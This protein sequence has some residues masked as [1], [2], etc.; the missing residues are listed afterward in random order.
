MVQYKKKTAYLSFS[1]NKSTSD[2]SN[3]ADLTE[4]KTAEESLDR[5]ILERLQQYG[6]CLF[7]LERI[8]TVLELK[9][10]GKVALTCLR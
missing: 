9:P 6:K 8:H 7:Y 5:A 1:R 2:L 3:M 10:S 4:G